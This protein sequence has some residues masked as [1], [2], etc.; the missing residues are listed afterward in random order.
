MGRALDL[1][2][3]F[4]CKA[5]H[6]GS[7]FFDPELDIFKAIA[8]EQPLFAEWRRFSLHEDAVCAPDGKTKH[9]VWRLARD[10]LQCP[11]DA[12]N[13]ATR[14]KCIEYLEVQ[15][16]AGLRKMYDPKLALRD[17]LTSVEGENSYE[18]SEQAHLDLIGCHATNDAL[19]E[20]VFGTY[21]MILRRCP[22]ISMEAASG[23]A[24]SVRSLM[25]SHGDGVAH[26]KAKCKVERK[27]YMGY[28]YSL[29]E[30]EQEALVEVARI[31]VTEMRRIDRTDH[32]ELDEYHKVRA[33]VAPALALTQFALAPQSRR[34]KNEEDE[35][36][37]LFNQYALALSFFERWCK[38]SVDTVG[39]VS[40]TLGGYDGT[41]VTQ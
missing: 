30:K 13:A 38:R 24:Q 36:D 35:L 39:A 1:V 12:A 14:E 19:A 27:P 18:N 2:E 33:F 32:R 11:A 29:P 16:A 15:S 9:L 7:L 25:L 8:D 26:R 41:Q 28:V 17:K 4:L 6:D 5:Q 34:K 23:V 31:T 37:A 21:D 40:V 3:Q 20:S 22:G 10:E